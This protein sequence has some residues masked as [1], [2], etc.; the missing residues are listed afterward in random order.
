[1]DQ[2]SGRIIC[3]AHGKGRHHDFCLLKSSKVRVHQETRILADSG[4]QGLQKLH[5][6]TS[7]PKKRSKK[8]PLTREEKKGNRE[9]SSIRVRIENVNAVL[10]RFHI[11]ADKY[12]NRRKRFGLRFTLIAALY[13]K[14]LPK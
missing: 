7:L 6:N 5:K 1:M 11:L 2:V 4:Y 12:R 13:N 8:V 14:D 3:L 10:K 9:Q